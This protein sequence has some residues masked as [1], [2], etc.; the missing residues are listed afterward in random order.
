VL[1]L[2]YYKPFKAS[3]PFIQ[4]HFPE[5]DI[6]DYTDKFW[7]A[8]RYFS[9]VK[10]EDYLEMYTS[11]Y[12][13]KSFLNAK[14]LVYPICFMAVNNLFMLNYVF[15]EQKIAIN[16]H[17]EKFTMPFRKDASELQKLSAKI[18]KYDGW[19]ILDLTEKEYNDWTHDEK[20]NNIKGW[21]KAAK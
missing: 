9:I 10:Q 3:K 16:F 11:F 21:L 7:Y 15:N 19:E 13:F 5:W 6:T 4:H 20:I 17:L 1:P 18:L 12:S 14:C 8:E 2:I